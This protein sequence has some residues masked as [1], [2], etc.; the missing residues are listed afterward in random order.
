MN[1]SFESQMAMIL[2][3]G[4]TNVRKIIKK[5]INRVLLRTDL[6]IRWYITIYLCMCIYILRRLMLI[7]QV[8][9]IAEGDR[10]FKK[11]NEPTHLE[12]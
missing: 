6:S 3:P 4:R 9:T 12:N 2:K 11:R 5:T 10:G 7:V 1:R 8:V